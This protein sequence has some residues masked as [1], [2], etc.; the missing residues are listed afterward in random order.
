MKLQAL[1]ACFSLIDKSI[2]RHAVRK[3]IASKNIAIDPKTK[4]GKGYVMKTQFQVDII[5]G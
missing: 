1:A 2:L 5:L 4:N 3:K